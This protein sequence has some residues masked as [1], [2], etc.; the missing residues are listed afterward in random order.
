MT[1]QFGVHTVGS[2]VLRKKARKINKITPA[3]KETVE[4]M[5]QVLEKV[6][7]AG[8]SGPQ[9]GLSKNIIIVN[10]G[11]I[12]EKITLFNPEI[13]WESEDFKPN[14]EGCLSLPG[15]LSEIWR[16][17]KIEVKGMGLNGKEV[18]LKARGIFAKAIQHEID[19]LNG[20][21]MFDYSPSEDRRAVIEYFKVDEDNIEYKLLKNDPLGPTKEQRIEKSKLYDA[22]GVE[23]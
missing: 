3:L 12:G 2:D 6:K 15:V 1:K 22:R 14:K 16:P 20:I 4:K 21:L 9:V 18:K 7:G 5:W 10:T 23:I 8:L 19:H 11:K 17:D 13:T